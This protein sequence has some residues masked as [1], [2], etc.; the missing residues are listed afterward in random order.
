MSIR[1]LQRVFSV[2]ENMGN[3][4]SLACVYVTEGFSTLEM[5]LL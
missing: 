4:L 3:T 1:L 5:H 2:L